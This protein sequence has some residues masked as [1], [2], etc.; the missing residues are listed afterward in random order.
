MET[1][2]HTMVLSIDIAINQY[3]YLLFATVH[4]LGAYT[5]RRPLQTVTCTK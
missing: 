2:S 4:L 3:F 5:V 1:D